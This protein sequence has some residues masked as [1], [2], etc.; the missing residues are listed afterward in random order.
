MI[1]TELTQASLSVRNRIRDLLNSAPLMVIRTSAQG[2]PHGVVTASAA[3]QIC[4][5]GDG[6]SYDWYIA[7]GGTAWKATWEVGWGDGGASIYRGETPPPNPAKFPQWYKPSTGQTFVYT[8]EGAW[9]ENIDIAAVDY[10]DT[11]VKTLASNITAYTLTINDRGCL[12]RFTAPGSKSL[13]IPGIGVGGFAPAKG[14]TFT[15]RNAS[16]GG[17]VTIAQLPGSAVNIACETGANILA[18]KT[19]GQLVHV[20]DSTNDYDL[21]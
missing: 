12:I 10:E 2:T 5:V 6:P 11:V 19:T 15:V 20:T 9:M 14:A 8:T 17:T 3:G 4:R 7:M 1:D 16:D 21:I 18:P 13:F